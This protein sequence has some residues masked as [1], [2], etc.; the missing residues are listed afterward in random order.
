VKAHYLYRVAKAKRKFPDTPVHCA[1][2]TKL[3]GVALA[4]SGGFSVEVFVCCI[5][6]AR[7]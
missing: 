7:S 1:M 5:K 4:K 6:E 2:E 3:Q